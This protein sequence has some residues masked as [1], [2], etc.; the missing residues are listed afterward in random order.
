MAHPYDGLITENELRRNPPND[1]HEARSNSIKI[2]PL[3][4]HFK[5]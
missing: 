5:G 2:A 1:Q 3:G 4:R